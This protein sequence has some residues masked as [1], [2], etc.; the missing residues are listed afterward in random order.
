MGGGSNSSGEGWSRTTPG[1]TNELGA[2][3]QS[4]LQGTSGYSKQ[5][6]VEDV[7]GLMR[8]QATN[9]MQE[10]L[11]KIAG[12][13]NTAGAYNST[14]KALLNND[15]QA[16]IMGQ[17]A[18]TQ[19]QAIKDYGALESDRIRAFSAATQAATSSASE[20]FENARSRQ[21][22]GSLINGIGGAAVGG[23][24]DRISS[25]EGKSTVT[26]P[27][28]LQEFADG[29]RV[30]DSEDEN[31]LTQ[32]IKRLGLTQTAEAIDPS[33]RKITQQGLVEPPQHADEKKITKPVTPAVPK[34]VTPKAPAQLIVQNDDPLFALL[35]TI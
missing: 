14:T 11:P 8:Q 2:V 34:A 15:L 31:L 4:S 33:R 10:V 35:N 7:Q 5:N 6:A 24:L 18:A 19:S 22:W 16:R 27:G 23:A 28:L 30:P 3:L 32:V 29:G 9:A 25:K 1:F 20:H 21:G 12:M 17:L 26:Y 13:Q